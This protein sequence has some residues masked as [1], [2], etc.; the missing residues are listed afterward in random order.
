MLALAADVALG[1]GDD[2]VLAAL[3]AENWF[4]PILV[5]KDIGSAAD[6]PAQIANWMLVTRKDNADLSADCTGGWGSG[7][8][9]HLKTAHNIDCEPIVFSEGS[10][11]TTQD[12][13]LGFVNLRDQMY[14]QFREALDPETGDDVMLP[15]DAR[16][17]AELT[18]AR[19]SIKGTNIKVE[20]KDEI[21]KRVGASP[22]EADAVVMAWYRR[23][24]SLKPAK[25]RL[26]PPRTGGWMS[27]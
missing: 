5:R 19:Y 16:L 13:K 10:N 24:A 21:K 20:S 6:L 7:V 1:G 2:S 15:P 27:R 8:R 14:W 11:L 18:A 22:D 25:P 9:S 3:H 4:A 26:P 23:A 17:M 12:G